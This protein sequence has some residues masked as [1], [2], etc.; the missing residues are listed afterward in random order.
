[1][2]SIE[3][4]LASINT[5]K[6]CIEHVRTLVLDNADE[7]VADQ[8]SMEQLH[9]LCSL[10]SQSFQLCISTKLPSKLSA[11]RQLQLFEIAQQYMQ[12]PVQVS[13]KSSD[14]RKS[15]DPQNLRSLDGIKQFSVSNRFV[16]QEEWKFG[17]LCYLSEVAKI[18]QAMIYVET[19]DKARWLFKKM[20]SVHES[21]S[22]KTTDMSNAECYY[23][24]VAFRSGSTHYMVLTAGP[25]VDIGVSVKIWFDV[26]ARFELYFDALAEQHGRKGVAVSFMKGGELQWLDAVQEYFDT[27]IEEFAW[28]RDY[29][30]L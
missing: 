25:T 14:H 21:V 1:M 2:D 10:L 3:N 18:T 30:Y 15:S 8:F 27:I 6:L 17:T 20:E 16:D 4:V 29:I 24:D 11:E 12:S 22:L 13:Y 26:P 9:E 28:K 7:L 23:A 19:D 5:G